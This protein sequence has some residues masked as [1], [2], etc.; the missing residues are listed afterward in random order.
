MAVPGRSNGLRSRPR[1]FGQLLAVAGLFLLVPI[2][3]F[4]AIELAGELRTSPLPHLHDFYHGFSEGD[5]SDPFLHGEKLQV[6]EGIAQPTIGGSSQEKLKNKVEDVP[7][8]AFQQIGG[9][10]ELVKEQYNDLTRDR[11]AMRAAVDAQE[12]GCSFA[13]G[14]DRTENITTKRL[15]DEIAFKNE[16]GGVWRQG[17]PI[18]YEGSEWDERKLRV[19]VVPHSHNDPGWIRT[20]EEYYHER[21]F[22]ILNVIVQALKEDSRRKFIWEEMSYLSMWWSDKRVTQAQKDDF[23]WL[24]TT[25]QLEIVGG[26]WVM[27]DEANSHH[28][29]IIDQV[30]GCGMQ[31]FEHSKALRDQ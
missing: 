19:F 3:T 1:G 17:W 15:Y 21:T 11:P 5:D 7:E 29:A 25:G 4:V 10:G 8:F 31:G 24:V 14:V 16:E 6:Q 26:G 18:T 13:L 2:F 22:N 27:N 9:L 28:F 23:K 12:P 30:R 20:V